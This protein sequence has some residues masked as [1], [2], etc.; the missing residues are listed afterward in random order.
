MLLF[1]HLDYSFSNTKIQ[2]K[3][4]VKQN[5]SNKLWYALGHV[6]RNQWMPVSDGFKDKSKAEKWAQSQSKV[7]KSAG[8]EVGGV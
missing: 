6:G 2:L 4:I 3:Y 5:P 7:D 1:K 8:K